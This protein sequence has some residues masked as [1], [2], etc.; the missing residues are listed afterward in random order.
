[1]LSLQIKQAA[2]QSYTQRSKASRKKANSLISLSLVKPHL[3]KLSLVLGL[4]DQEGCGETGKRPKDGCT[5]GQ[6]LEFQQGDVKASEIVWY[7]ED[8]V[9]QRHN[10][11]L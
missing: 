9:K 7:C 5:D 3:A 1:M 4:P 2:E 11:S 6:Y 8:E 10:C